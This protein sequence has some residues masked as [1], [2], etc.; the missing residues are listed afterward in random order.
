MG[1]GSLMPTH[2]IDYLNSRRE[3]IRNGRAQSA[4]H[5]DRL[6]NP[7]DLKARDAALDAGE[8]L[9]ESVCAIFADF[10]AWFAESTNRLASGFDANTEIPF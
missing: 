3:A 2:S 9:H 6:V 1:L 10:R 5:A 8:M 7:V 4:G